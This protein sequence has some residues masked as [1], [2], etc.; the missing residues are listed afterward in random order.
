MSTV[1][2]DTSAS[3][4]I[5]VFLTS[6][7]ADFQ[8]DLQQELSSWLLNCVHCVSMIRTVKYNVRQELKR[9]VIN[10]QYCVVRT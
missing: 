8:G 1:P 3:G 9:T 10:L 2:V 6:V 7:Y 4:L 5:P